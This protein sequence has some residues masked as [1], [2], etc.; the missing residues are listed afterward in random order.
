MFTLRSS[1]KLFEY[2]PP[3]TFSN[4]AMKTIYFYNKWSYLFYYSD[5]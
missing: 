4:A 3:D 1:F 2:I 5:K